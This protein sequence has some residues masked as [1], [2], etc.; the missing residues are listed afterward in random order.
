MGLQAS[1]NSLKILLSPLIYSAALWRCI[2]TI[3]SIRKIVPAWQRTHPFDRHHGTD[4]SGI[5]PRHLIVA[6]KKLQAQI[7]VYGGSQPSIVRRAILAL[8]DVEQYSFVDLGCGKGRPMIVASE[9]PFRSIAGVELSSQLARVAQRNIATVERRFPTRR[10]PSVIE[11]NAV[12]ST[13]PEGDLVVFLY[14]PFGGDILTQIVK[15]LE[16]SIAREGVRLMLIYYNPVHGHLVDAS[17]AFTRW[18]AENLSYDES[19]MGFGPDTG[20]AVVIWKSV[21]AKKMTPHAN[22][23]RP[24]LVTKPLWKAEVAS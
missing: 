23:D 14:H 10:R 11:G 6:D 15:R 12:T 2:E 1:K 21:N 16:N 24:I 22:A 7:T 13:Y 5:V 4:T 8:G 17:P 9:F 19:E 20:D 18:Y 3:P